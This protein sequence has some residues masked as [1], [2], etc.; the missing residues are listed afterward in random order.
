MS[1]P[2][3]L[4]HKIDLFRT[5]ARVF[6]YEEELFSRPSWVAVLLG[7]NIVPRQCDPIV[8]SLPH[9]MVH[10]SLESMRLA[11]AQASTAMPTHEEFIRR[12]CHAGAGSS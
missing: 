10:E 5:A 1:I 3:T 11:M 8:A 4:R 6:R 2:D 7:Q 12:Y 9:A